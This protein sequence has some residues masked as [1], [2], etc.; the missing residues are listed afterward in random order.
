MR[1]GRAARVV[2][3]RDDLL[4]NLMMWP[5]TLKTH[6]LWTW[7][8]GLLGALVLYV[9]SFPMMAIAKLAGSTHDY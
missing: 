4:R 8:F 5:Q 9:F 6:G 2:S 7:V 3:K 1:S